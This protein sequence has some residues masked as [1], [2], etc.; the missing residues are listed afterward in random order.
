VDLVKAFEKTPQ[1]A[2]N[3]VD[4]KIEDKVD[5]DYYNE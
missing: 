2:H 1:Q 5:S 4:S 3:A